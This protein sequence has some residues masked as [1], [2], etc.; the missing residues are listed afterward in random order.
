MATAKEKPASITR[1]VKDECTRVRAII[2][3]YEEIADPASAL[4]ATWMSGLVKHS[5]DAAASADA[6]ECAAC[7]AELR[8]I[9]N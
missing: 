4:A 9:V 3:H 1:A 8:R 2:R 5:E 6:K 7:L